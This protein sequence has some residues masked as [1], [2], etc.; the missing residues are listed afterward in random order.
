[1]SRAERRQVRAIRELEKRFVVG[2]RLPD[3]IL[4]KA[5]TE[6]VSG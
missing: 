1:M 2:A 5:I 6:V 3:N 4:R